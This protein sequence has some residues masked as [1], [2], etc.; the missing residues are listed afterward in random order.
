MPRRIRI[1]AFLAAA[2]VI[3]GGCSAPS[4][5]LELITTAR[6]ALTE[7]KQTQTAQHDDLVKQLEANKA[8]LD[9]A[10]DADVALAAAGGLKDANGQAVPFTPQWVISARRGYAA[11]RD[12]LAQQ[13]QQVDAANAVNQ[14]NLNAAD[15]SLDMAAQ[16]IIA[17]W[18]VAERLRTQ[19]LN[20]QRSLTHG[21]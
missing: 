11:A 7:A 4:A 5:T 18:N 8:A 1:A 16:L 3:L 12:V 14:D 19:L 17:Q 9:A 6:K 13:V 2:A 15:E 20:A 10:F 21:Q